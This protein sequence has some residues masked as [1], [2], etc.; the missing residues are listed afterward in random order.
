MSN[1]ISV[2]GQ[3]AL[4][5]WDGVEPGKAP[6]GVC[7]C[8]LCVFWA[9]HWRLEGLFVLLKE[10]VRFEWHVFGALMNRLNAFVIQSKLNYGSGRR[11]HMWF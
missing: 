2:E 11:G 4:L 1:A 10:S 3:L 5:W 6:Y 8:M 7:C 9:E